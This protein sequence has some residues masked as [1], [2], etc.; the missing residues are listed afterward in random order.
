MHADQSRAVVIPT[1][2]GGMQQTYFVGLPNA[3]F[4][5]GLLSCS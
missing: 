5:L 2:P 4:I 3:F 1:F